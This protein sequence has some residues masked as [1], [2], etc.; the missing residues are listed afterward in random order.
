MSASQSSREERGQGAPVLEG[1]DPRL[2]AFDYALP[3]H[4]IAR[5]PT[6]DRAESRLLVVDGPR[7]VA[8]TA[9][10]LGA[11]LRPGDLLVVNDTAVMPARLRLRRRSGG[12][13]EALLLAPGPGPVPAMMRPSRRL[14]A[15]E[16]LRLDP[17]CAALPDASLRV[18]QRLEE[19]LF[20]VEVSPSP[21]AVM[22]AAGEIPL[23]PY[24]NRAEEPGDRERYQTVYAAS[25]GA[26]AAPTAGLHLSPALLAS[27]QASGVGLAR[28][29]LHV[30]P[31][32]FR[33]LRPEDLDRGLLHPETWQ[34][35]PETAEAV[36][37]TRARGGAVV[38]VGTTTVRTLE[39]AALRPE[40]FGPG[41]GTTRLF[42]QPGFRFQIT[43]RLLTNFHLPRSSLL[44]LVSAFGGRDPVLSAYQEAISLGFR[45]Y[46]Y[47]D[48]MLVSPERPR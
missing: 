39:S 11:W 1:A 31:G 35:P 5:Y 18:A 17:P 3:A 42:I 14:I 7:R 22:D 40:G 4:Q 19:G 28:V 6:A 44:M 29:T 33:N 38:A 48:A 16:V 30:G 36:A 25:P 12:A 24:L 32:T 10:D 8:C 41:Q 43:D 9:R 45:F 47:G 23:P 37:A 34:I 20:R 21:L 15:G 27:L 2:L 26:V 46:S 13:V